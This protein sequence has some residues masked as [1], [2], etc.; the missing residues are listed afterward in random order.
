MLYQKIDTAIASVK[1]NRPD[2]CD[3]TLSLF[4]D[5]AEYRGALV[6]D[7][8][9]SGLRLVHNEPLTALLSRPRFDALGELIVVRIGELT[10]ALTKRQT[11]LD[12]FASKTGKRFYVV[13]E[14]GVLAVLRDALRGLTTEVLIRPSRWER[15]FRL[16]EIRGEIRQH[17]CGQ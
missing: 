17:G 11:E 12:R 8:E 10:A 13:C 9:R 14:P 2:L 16:G 5:D 1:Q 4:A 3:A 6:N 15:M 7:C